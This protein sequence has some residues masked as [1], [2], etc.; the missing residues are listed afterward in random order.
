MKP[1]AIA[2]ARAKEISKLG[3]DEV[4]IVGANYNTGT[5]HVTTYGKSLAACENA[6]KGGNAIKKLLNWP[7]ELCNAKPKRQFKREA[8][9]QREK[10]LL[11]LVEII[12]NPNPNDIINL[13]LFVATAMKAKILL[14]K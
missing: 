10:V 14:K 5:Q 9:E 8:A 12:D 1:K 3:Y 13:S 7:P 2:I 4:I 6:A 11:E